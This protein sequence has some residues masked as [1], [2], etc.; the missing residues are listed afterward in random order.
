MIKIGFFFICLL[1]LTL[2]GQTF[3]SSAK[4]PAYLEARKN[5]AEAYLVVEVTDDDSNPVPG[6]L[7][8]VHM[9]LNFADKGN[10]LEG[11]TKCGWAFCCQREDN[12]ECHRDRSLKVR[13]V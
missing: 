2:N 8:R 10:H 12:G 3:A 6:V 4:D 9:G 7:V 1:L 11:V 5:G 13:M